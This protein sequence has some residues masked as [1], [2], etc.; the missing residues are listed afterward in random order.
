MINNLVSRV[1]IITIWKFHFHIRILN[2]DFSS[3]LCHL[4][5]RWD[6]IARVGNLKSKIIKRRCA[7]ILCFCKSTSF[8]CLING[9]RCLTEP[10]TSLILWCTR[11]FRACNHLLLNRS[12]TSN[13][14]HWNS[15]DTF[16]MNGRFNC[17]F[18]TWDTS[19]CPLAP[20]IRLASFLKYTRRWLPFRLLSLLC[21]GGTHTKNC[22]RK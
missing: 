4:D 20:T 22:K 19:A 9:Y 5:I 21:F 1:L 11:L 2:M 13:S 16:C 6:G 10:L 3:Y 12:F 7:T 17:R 18:M 15:T 8:T 14:S